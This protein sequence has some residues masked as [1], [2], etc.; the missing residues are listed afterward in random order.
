M[1]LRLSFTGD[2]CLGLRVRDTLAEQGLQRLFAGLGNS[3]AHSDA[4]VTNLECYLSPL[5][6]PGR[7]GRMAAPPEFADA[8]PA[9]GIRVVGLA[10]NHVLDHG[11]SGLATTLAAL[12]AR[13]I[14]H[15]GAG[16][17]LTAAE[18]V[19]TL[20]MGGQRIALLG[21][22]DFSPFHAQPQAAGV[23]PLEEARLLTRVRNAAQD[24]GIVV[25]T[26][27]ADVEFS[28]HPGPWRIAL[29]RRLIDAGA[30]LVIQHHP[31]VTQGVERYRHGL[32]AYSL[33]NFVFAVNDNAYQRPWPETRRSMILHV[34]LPRDPH[35]DAELDWH[36]QAIGIDDEHCPYLLEEEAAA[37]FHQHFT[38]LC[39]DLQQPDT[40]QRHWAPHARSEWTARLKDA[41]WDVR[42]GKFR[43]A[44]D[45]LRCLR[46]PEYRRMLR[47]LLRRPA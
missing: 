27:H 15:Y 14:L 18:R 5:A 38:Q 12:D 43:R 4:V 36:V 28:N 10:N 31:H 1:T 32:I 25:V 33:G 37:A 24:H 17:D 34:D 45:E 8:L 2:L 22:C 20:E 47:G 30:R 44:L 35:G 26:L 13:Q 7:K 23:A 3:L 41:Y 46:R 21:A 19:L 29:S 11:A 9:A 42:R 39:T 6:V 16:S 40:V